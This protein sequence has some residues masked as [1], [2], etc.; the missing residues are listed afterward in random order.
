MPIIAPQQAARLSNHILQVPYSYI[1]LSAKQPQRSP[2][3]I[4]EAYQPLAFSISWFV[5]PRPLSRFVAFKERRVVEY[6]TG[7]SM[8][9]QVGNP[10]R[11]TF[12]AFPY[13]SL[14]CLHI[15]RVKGAACRL[16]CSRQMVQ[17]DRST[18]QRNGYSYSYLQNCCILGYIM[19]VRDLFYAGKYVNEIWSD[20]NSASGGVCLEAVLRDGPVFHRPPSGC[21]TLIINTEEIPEQSA[22]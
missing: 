15:M 19:D 2:S 3:I 22:A 10:E 21:D 6:L 1:V 17:F 4:A 13:P 16:V 5:P 9:Q 18:P 11:R 12:H 20:L 14:L 7:P 8:E